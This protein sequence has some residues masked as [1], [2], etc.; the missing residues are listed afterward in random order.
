MEI[1][2]GELADFVSE[3]GGVEVRFNS[4]DRE[5]EVGGLDSF[6]DALIAAVTLG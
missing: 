2:G 3:A 6:A 5:N 4:T 1:D